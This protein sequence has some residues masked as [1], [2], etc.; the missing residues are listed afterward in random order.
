MY[1]T[2]FSPSGRF[3]VSGGADTT[4]KLW[5]PTAKGEEPAATHHDDDDPRHVPSSH[6]HGGP[7][8]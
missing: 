2:Q 6:P 8:H 1:S 3:L 5:Q 7:D 4:I